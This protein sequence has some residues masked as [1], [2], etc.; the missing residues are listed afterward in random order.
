[1]WP[2]RKQHCNFRPLQQYPPIATKFRM[3]K[4]PVGSRQFR[5]RRHPCAMPRAGRTRSGHAARSKSCP[6]LNN[7]PMAWCPIKPP[8]K[9]SSVWQASQPRRFAS[10]QA[11]KRPRPNDEK[12]AGQVLHWT[13]TAL[14]D[15]GMRLQ[16]IL[17]MSGQCRSHWLKIKNPAAPAVT[18]SPGNLP[19]SALSCRA[20][21]A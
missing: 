21:P 10:R 13:L 1:M 15:G 2:G 7:V 5:S 6:A 9:M 20:R 14:L 8:R 11:S 4:P 12:A 3:M 17:A 18:R 16:F 19:R